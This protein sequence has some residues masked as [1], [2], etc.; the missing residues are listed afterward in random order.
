MIEILKLLKAGDT[1]AEDQKTFLKSQILFWL[2]G[3]T[4]GHAKNVSIS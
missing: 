2:I 3:A 4:D 1:A